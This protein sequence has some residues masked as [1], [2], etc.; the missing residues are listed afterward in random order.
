MID[1]RRDPGAIGLSK[2]CHHA[3][4]DDSLVYFSGTGADEIISDYGFGGKKLTP[5]SS[6]GGLF[7]RNLSSVFPWYNFFNGTQRAYLMKEELVAGSYGIE[8]RYPFLDVKLVQEFLFLSADVKNSEYKRPIADVL[9]DLGCPGDFGK[10]VP[11]F[12]NP[13]Q[14]QQQRRRHSATDDAGSG[15]VQHGSAQEKIEI[16]D[17]GRASEYSGL[18]RQE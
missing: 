10:K 4:K 18:E 6:F 11:F 9:R 2:V 17:N 13:Q 1:M 15:Q 3:R 14:Q 7:P 12:A 5:H 8:A 16:Q